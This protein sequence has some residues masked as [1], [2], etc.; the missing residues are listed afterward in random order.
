MDYSQPFSVLN[1]RLRPPFTS[2]D[3]LY[4]SLTRLEGRHLGSIGGRSAVYRPTI[5]PVQTQPRVSVAVSEPEEPEDDGEQRDLDTDGL[6]EEVAPHVPAD[7]SCLLSELSLTDVGEEK[8]VEEDRRS[9]Q[10]DEKDSPGDLSS[11]QTGESSESAN[12]AGEGSPFQRH[13]IDGTL[14]DLIKSG[15]PLGRRRTVSHVSDT[16][17]EVR[18]E[19]ELSRR[20]SV[21]LKA[22]V[23]KLQEN[24]D[25]PGWSQHRERVTEEVLSILRLLHPLTDPE[26]SLSTHSEGENRLDAAL[27]QL[28][29]VAR[30]LAINHTNQKVRPGKGHGPEDSSILQQA[31]R[32]R[33][34]AIEKKK[35]MEAELLRS[36]TEM[37]CLNNQLLE[38]VQKRLELSL[39]VEAWKEDFQLMLQ[40]QVQYQQQSEQSQK[41]SSRLGILRRNNKPPIQRPANFPLPTTSAATATPTPTANS[42]QASIPRPPVST[43]PTPSMPSSGTLRWKLRKGKSSRQGDQDNVW[44]DPQRDRDEAGFQVVSL[45]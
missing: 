16:L 27:V 5:L 39:E 20:R 25:G 11:E 45:D 4:N 22:Q 32:D 14:P 13:Y 41:K 30:I 18:R 26:S 8:L 40:Q 44:S 23:D 9:C 34:E 10:S 15:R 31:L 36:K 29:S 6:E 38:A 19:V 43:A 28:Q 35:A 1:E 2:S 24:R 37:M 12:S 42:N 17:K 21:K 7:A 33:D 3:Q